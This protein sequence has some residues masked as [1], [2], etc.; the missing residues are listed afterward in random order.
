MRQIEIRTL[1]ASDTTGFLRLKQI[2]LS[3]DP[4]SFVASLDEDPPDYAQRVAARLDTASVAEGDVVIGAFA[5][6]ELVGIVAVTRDPHSKRR[7]K[8]DLHGMYVCPAFRGRGIGRALLI[9]VLRLATQMPALEAIQLIVATH[10]REAATLYRHF[11]FVDMWTESRALRVGGEY[12]DAHHMVL[13]L[14]TTVSVPSS[15]T[16]DAA[17]S[18]LPGRP[19]PRCSG[20]H[21]G[22]SPAF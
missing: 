22:I 21:P 10:N 12:V 2:G 3:T 9:E 14:P 18:S 17:S 8:A 13:T 19:T 16:K 4:L 1:N 7:H 20:H 5:G 6:S 11:G 15:P